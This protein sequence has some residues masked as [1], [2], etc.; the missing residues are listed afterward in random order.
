MTMKKRF[1]VWARTL[2]MLTLAFGLS[3]NAYGQDISRLE[4]RLRQ[5]EALVSEGQWDE[6]IKELTAV[7]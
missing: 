7:I 6:A 3:W 1:L 2:S 5:G 4:E